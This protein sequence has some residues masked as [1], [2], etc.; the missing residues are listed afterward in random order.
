MEDR[1]KLIK[2]K[3]EKQ[4][5]IEIIQ[6]QGLRQIVWKILINE[7]KYE[8]N[9]IKIDPQFKIIL[10]NCEAVV[11]IDFLIIINSVNFMVIRCTSSTIESWERYIVA[12]A[13]SVTDYQIPYAVV[14]DGEHAKIIDVL[15][16]SLIGESIHDLPGKQQAIDLLKDFKKIS[17]PAEKI[18]KEKRIVY[19]FEGIKCPAQPPP[20]Q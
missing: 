16:V 6:L 4:E 10:N 13:R 12:F 11:S 7:K 19:A 18:A 15:K 8:L 14:T 3:I 2:E 17:C 20:S 5:F 9:D 1:E